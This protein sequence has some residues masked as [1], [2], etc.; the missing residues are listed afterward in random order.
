MQNFEPRMDQIGAAVADT[1]RSRMLCELMSGRA[2]TNKELAAL[3]GIEPQTATAHLQKLRD[4]GLTQAERSGRCIYHRL[5]G[6]L[7]A[8]ALETLAQLSPSDHLYCLPEGSAEAGD[9]RILRSCYS[10]LAGRLAVRMTAA[11][12]D[13]QVLVDDCGGLALGPNA[14]SFAARLGL[15]WP[16]ARHNSARAQGQTVKACLDWSERRP[17]VGGHFA[18]ALMERGLDAG[19][20][21]R[22]ATGL[23]LQLA[24]EGE[25]VLQQVFGIDQGDFG[26]SMARP[27]TSAVSETMKREQGR[28][29]C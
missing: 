24:R 26:P 10:H 27:D 2:Y 1:S 25:Q 5:A 14:D 16:G 9:A 17:H 21:R 18:R 28:A 7:V 20:F 12:S 11:M 29:R 6:E 19:C 13:R 15:S 22:C 3:A 4:A 23:A 8:D